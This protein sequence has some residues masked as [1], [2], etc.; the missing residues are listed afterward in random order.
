MATNAG[1]RPRSLEVQRAQAEERR[2]RLEEFQHQLE[3]RKYELEQRKHELEKTKV[4]ND[5]LKHFITVITALLLALAY[6]GDQI[7]P[8]LKSL[9]I[10]S[11]IW[12]LWDVAIV[13][14]TFSLTFSLITLVYS[15]LYT[16]DKRM[17]NNTRFGL[18][19]ILIALGVVISLAVLALPRPL[20]P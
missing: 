19:V 2:Q 9:N 11:S 15:A 8:L 20:S 1:D 17:S 4:I 12:N 13:G 18:V 10:R 16:D 7:I 5:V 6:F 3:I 14:L